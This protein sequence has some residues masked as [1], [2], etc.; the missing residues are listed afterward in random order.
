MRIAIKFLPAEV[1][2]FIARVQRAA[3]SEKD[4]LGF[5]PAFVYENQA[6]EGNIYVA[7]CEDGGS[8]RYVG[9]LFFRCVF[10]HAHIVQLVVI[11]EFRRLRVGQKLLH[12]LISLTEKHSYLDIRAAVASDLPANEFYEKM[13][14]II[15]RTRPGGASRKRTINIRVKHLDTLDL[16]RMAATDATGLGIVDKLANRQAVYVIDL[17]VFWDV[18]RHRARSEYGNDI[19]RAAFHRLINMVITPEFVRE[20]E[21]TSVVPSNDPALEFALQ[22]PVLSDPDPP[23]TQAIMDKI[24][25]LV[26]PDRQ[27]A[28]TLSSQDRSDLIHLA[29]A[30]HHSANGFVTSERAILRASDSIFRLYGVEVIHVESLSSVLRASQ[31]PIPA[32]RAQLSSDTLYIVSLAQSTDTLETFLKETSAPADFRSD[33]VSASTMDTSRTRIAVSS[34]TEMVCLASWDTAAGLQ[35]RATVRLIANGEHVAVETALNCIVH[36]VCKE[37][38]KAGPVLLRLIT[39]NGQAES[40]KA[41]LQHG[42]QPVDKA[43]DEDGIVL[44]KLCIGRPITSKNWTRIRRTLEQ[45]SGLS[46]EQDFPTID[47]TDISVPFKV[48]D[49]GGRTLPLSRLEKMLSPT[50]FALPDRHA[51]IAPI[52]RGYA[53]QLFEGSPQMSLT[54]KREA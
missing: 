44:Q 1:M 48:S 34:D 19:I 42:F 5:L 51:Y 24:A 15:S 23:I 6:L 32:F 17:N 36:Q 30:I 46:F 3:D 29:V 7:V 43:S 2:P 13:G 45:C 14:F 37:A 39:P 28:G 8:N 38:S 53:E 12:A 11:P 35:G 20:L 10:P 9:H 31:K 26:F 22:L 40:Q 25:P 16:F 41:A 52:R 18:V 50:I 47:A 54:P 33:F 49:G 27:K 21:R 4:A